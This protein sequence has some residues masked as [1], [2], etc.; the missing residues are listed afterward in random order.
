M[1]P[2]PFDWSGLIGGLIVAAFI[3][4]ATVYW[5]D[6]CGTDETQWKPVQGRTSPPPDYY[7]EQFERQKD[8]IYGT[9]G[10]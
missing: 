6:G 4:F 2:R 8:P 3:A 9:G 10:P 1:Y 5:I 7:R